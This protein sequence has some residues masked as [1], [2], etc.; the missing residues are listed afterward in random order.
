MTKLLVGLGVAEDRTNA[1][2]E[3]IDLESST[4]ICENLIPFPSEV[5]SATGGLGLDGR[6]LICGGLTENENNDICYSYDNGWFKSFTMIQPNRSFAA[7]SIS[8]YENTSLMVT[9]GEISYPVLTNLAEIITPSGWVQIPS[10]PIPIVHHCMV[11]INATTVMVI[12][13]YNKMFPFS[14]SSYYFNIAEET[15]KEGPLLTFGRHSH[16]CGIIRKTGKKSIVVVGGVNDS[17]VFL[18]SVE[19]LDDDATEWH[20]G[21]GVNSPT[22]Y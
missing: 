8:P 5:Y 19:I 15:W 2:F 4:N 7:S 11:T 18:R 9:G 21:P 13:G 3:V 17:G 20:S 14:A 1:E 6:P 12:G 16:K 22:S 10:L